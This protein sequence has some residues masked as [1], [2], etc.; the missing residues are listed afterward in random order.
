MDAPLKIIA[1]LRF[2]DRGGLRYLVVRT[3]PG[4]RAEVLRELRCVRQIMSF[5][6]ILN[7]V[8]SGRFTVAW[9]P[10]ATS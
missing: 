2:T 8:E 3:M 10:P 1:G 6:E 4:G 9:T 7:S 5:R